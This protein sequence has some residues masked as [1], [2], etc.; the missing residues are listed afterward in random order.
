ML[1]VSFADPQALR[2]PRPPRPQ[3]PQAVARASDLLTETLQENVRSNAL[4]A[5]LSVNAAAASSSPCHYSD[6]GRIGRPRRQRQAHDAASLTTESNSPLAS[7][8]PEQSVPQN[9]TPVRATPLPADGLVQPASSTMPEFDM[10]FLDN[11]PWLDWTNSAS[12]MSPSIAWDNFP[13]PANET[14][15]PQDAHSQSS[16]GRKGPCECA[17]L[18]HKHFSILGESHEGLEPLRSLRE[19]AQV[20]KKLLTCDVCFDTG[21]GHRGVTGNVYLLGA[22][23]SNIASSYAQFFVQQK[24]RLADKENE[25]QTL[26]LGHGPSASPDSLVELRVGS[27]E[28]LALLKSGIRV[29]ATSLSAICDEFAQRQQKLHNEGH[30]QCA[31]GRP[32][33][34]KDASGCSKPSQHSH[35]ICPK[36]ETDD[37]RRFFLCFQAVRM[38]RASIE[39]LQ[40]VL[41]DEALAS[42]YPRC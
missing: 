23:L 36:A 27:T 29:D 13:T 32:C 9:P 38:V 1:A 4:V 12:Q 18:A 5:H 2:S 37:P 17:I 19:A 24:T 20:A 39:E 34:S 6:V 10:A 3:V 33:Q 11:V 8:P 35:A 41:E 16:P 28:Y 31:Q 42:P 40:A 26:T 14:G 15:D 21:K 22:L 7:S 30:E 25:Q